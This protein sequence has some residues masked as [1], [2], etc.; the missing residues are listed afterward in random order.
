MADNLSIKYYDLPDAAPISATDRILIRQGTTDANLTGEMLNSLGF[1]NGGTTPLL[2]GN[3]TPTA[4]N[5]MLQVTGKGYFTDTVQIDGRCTIGNPN[6]GVFIKDYLGM[7]Y[8]DASDTSGFWINYRGYQDG[9]SY[10]RNFAVGDGKNNP[11][12]IWIGASNLIWDISKRIM[13]DTAADTGNGERLQVDGEGYFSG[14]VK[15]GSATPTA[16]AERLQV[17][18]TASIG[19]S[20]SGADAT[21]IEA[22]GTLTFKGAA[23]VW[24]DA[25]VDG[26]SLT[27]GATDP[28]SFQAITGTIYGNRFDNAA[29][30]SCHGSIEIPHD[31]KEGT[32]I[33]LHIHWI[34]T[35]TN[36]GN[37]RWGV[38]WVI[39]S[40]NG[41][42]SGTTSE[43]DAA[44]GG[45]ALAHKVVD[46]VTISGT[47][48]KISDVIHFRVFRNGTHANDTFTG[49]AFLSRIAVHYECDTVGSRQITTK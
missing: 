14:N 39:A 30:M 24:N 2:V 7:G 38:E 46:V 44:S 49:N 5:E 23:T 11:M 17:T 31:Y 18:G 35:T 45:T 13:N 3:S 42:Y 40:V 20:S 29:I 10:F 36:N 32:S 43:I 26:L 16:G 41:V 12:S 34:P 28:P 6:T 15:I 4:E 47:N 22:D 33:I 48:R 19:N 1:K 27:G 21:I 25:F 37:C 9:N 8:N